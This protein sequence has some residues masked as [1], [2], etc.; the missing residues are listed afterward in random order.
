GVV[1]AHE[2]VDEVVVVRVVAE[3]HVAADVVGEALVVGERRGQPA[4]VVG[5]LQDH[6]VVVA[7]LLEPVA[8]AQAGGA[9]ADDDDAGI[10]APVGLRRGHQAA[11]AAIGPEPAPVSATARAMSAMSEADSSTAAAPIHPST[12]SGLRA[13][14]MAADTPG[15]ASTHATASS[16]R[17]H[18]TRSAMRRSRSTRARLRERFGSWNSVA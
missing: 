16:G 15:Q 13:P 14:T 9:G 18:P 4:H 2:L 12:C 10:G 3:H 5:P 8:G 6:P 1:A 17:L 7:Q 11:S